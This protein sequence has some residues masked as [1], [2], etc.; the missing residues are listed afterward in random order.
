MRYL[1]ISTDTHDRG[2]TALIL[3]HWKYLN[4]GTLKSSVKQWTS[5]DRAE[6]E[7][8]VG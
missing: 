4:M 2:E 6:N 8:K 5:E 1:R 3:N 7:N